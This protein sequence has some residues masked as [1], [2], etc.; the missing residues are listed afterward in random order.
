[1]EDILEMAFLSLGDTT[2]VIEGYINFFYAQETCT[3][4]QC[5]FFPFLENPV[6]CF[7]KRK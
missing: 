5:F 3:K 1:M 6:A 4:K 7:Q 2:Y